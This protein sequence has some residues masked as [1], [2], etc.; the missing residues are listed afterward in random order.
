MMAVQDRSTP[1]SLNLFGG[2]LVF[3][4]LNS[5]SQPNCALTR[6]YLIFNLTINTMGFSGKNTCQKNSQFEM[7]CS[8]TG[9]NWQLHLYQKLIDTV[10]INRSNITEKTKIPSPEKTN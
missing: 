5:S 2:Y 3:F 7:F 10:V 6:L 4:P 8:V 9:N 1:F